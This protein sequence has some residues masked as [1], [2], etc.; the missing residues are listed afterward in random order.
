MWP[1]DGESGLLVKKAVQSFRVDPRAH[2]RR[3]R[4][5]LRCG[6]GRESVAGRASDVGRCDRE[7]GSQ[8]LGNGRLRTSS[9]ADI[10]LHQLRQEQHSR[11]RQRHGDPGSHGAISRRSSNPG[12]C[13]RRTAGRSARQRHPRLQRLASAECRD[14]LSYGGSDATG[15]WGSLPSKGNRPTSRAPISTPANIAWLRP[16]C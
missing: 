2:A 5:V 12:H 6:H 4:G 16:C 15:A 10:Y 9:P 13:S 7:P 11:L 1:A 8:L 3:D 14:A